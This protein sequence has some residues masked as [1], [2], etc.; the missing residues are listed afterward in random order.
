MAHIAYFQKAFV[1]QRQWLTQ[2]EFA[3]LVAICQSLPG[4]SSS[5]VGMAIGMRQ[6]GQMGALAAW[7]GFTLPSALFM[8][9]AAIG[10]L[11][12]AQDA[13][14]KGLLQGFA[15][16]AIVVIAQAIWQMQRTLCPD[17]PRR[18]VMVLVTVSVLS[19]QHPAMQVFVIAVAGMWGALRAPVDGNQALSQQSQQGHPIEA[20]GTPAMALFIA[21]LVGLP[22]LANAFGEPA[23]LI[24]DAYF[25][26]GALVFGG[27]HVVL[28]LL[29]EAVVVPGWVAPDAFLAGY[30]LAQAIPGPLFTVS[31]FLGASGALGLPSILAGSL[32]LVS[33]FLP[34]YLLLIGVLPLWDKLK[35]RPSWQ[36]ALA[37]INAAVVGLLVSALVHALLAFTNLGMFTQGYVAPTVCTLLAVLL[38]RFTAPSWLVVIACAATSVLLAQWVP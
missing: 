5:Q 17:W 18:G 35:H 3:E 2:A 33:I 12:G 25:R 7:L 32:A 13:L 4:P 9:L 38:M 10:L 36:R 27:G 26:A 29:Q 11:G 1:V 16:A 30:G 34:G 24:M 14:P 31:A 21:L 6:G 28:P 20:N 22:L 37:S 19:I 15:L 23:L 8:L